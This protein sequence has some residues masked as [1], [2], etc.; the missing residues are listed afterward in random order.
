MKAFVHLK[1]LPPLNLLILSCVVLFIVI[2]VRASVMED[3]YITFRVVDNVVNGYGLR[4]NLHERVQ[5]YTNP[6]WMFLHIPFYAMYR[7]I[8][9][10][11][12]M[13]SLVCTEIALFIAI[14]TFRRSLFALSCLFILPL[15]F[16]RA[17]TVYSTSGFEN[18]LEH[19]L[20]ACFGWCVLRGKPDKLWF[21]GSLCI[22][23]SMVNRLDTVLLYVP[24]SIYLYASR[25]SSL[26]IKKV[27][28][29]FSPIILWELF[30]LFYYG[31]LYPNTKYA[32]L[33]TGIPLSDYLG[34]GFSYVLNLM[35]LDFVSAFLIGGAIALIPFLWARTRRGGD[36]R[37]GLFLS[38]AV[39]IALYALYVISVGGTYLSGRLF[40]LPVFASA[41]VL[42][43]VV[44]HVMR[45]KNMVITAVALGGIALF[46]PPQSWVVEQCLPCVRGV[47]DI[48]SEA[49]DTPW[50]YLGGRITLPDA[51][52]LHLPQEVMLEWSMG[53]WG[54]RLDRNVKV[55]DGFAIVD[56]LMARLPMNVAHISTLGI[57]GRNVPKGYMHAVATGDTGEMDPDL[58]SY[59]QKLS[60]IT[61]GDL[62]SFERL[63]E[64]VKFNL[65]AYDYLR[66]QYVQKMPKPE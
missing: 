2:L 29:G 13:L 26:E 15:A 57:T 65:G 39:G 55:V 19:L 34:L 18:S 46:S 37:A 32:K 59:Y 47:D 14:A 61:S 38:L 1:R 7:N 12:L 16:S 45:E 9:W 66:D 35:T 60:L 42:V 22:A 25:R 31:F 4:W 53:R 50:A 49:K 3:A 64:I 58:A 17:F 11:T 10:D 52:S 63:T 40:S 20:F 30:S 27:A 21:T 54:Y 5:A 56:P 33:N 6:L 36:E 24:V 51:G 41:W 62:F 48:T 44:G 28:A 43:A 8:F 23:L